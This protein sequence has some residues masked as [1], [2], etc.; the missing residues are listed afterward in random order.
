MAEVRALIESLVFVSGDEGVTLPE[1]AD[2]LEL[3]EAE[4]EAEAEALKSVVN[5]RDGGF[6]MDRSGH[7]YRFVTVKE[8]APYIRRMMNPP[9]K[10]TLSRAA[11]ETLAII[12]YEQ[13]V[14]RLDIENIRGVKAEKAVQSLVGR[15]LIEARGRSEGSG[16]AILYG[17]TDQFLDTFDLTSLEELPPLPENENNEDDFQSADLFFASLASEE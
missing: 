7:S 2:V 12:A 6:Y 1:L 16:R 15:G 4:A 11:L 17:T 13:P 10:K 3:S 5:E 8:A 9:E 14:T